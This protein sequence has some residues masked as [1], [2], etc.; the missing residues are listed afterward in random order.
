MPE[1]LFRRKKQQ[2][3][4]SNT[5]N[6]VVEAHQDIQTAKDKIK[7]KDQATA[8]SAA[9]TPKTPRDERRKETERNDSILREKD[10]FMELYKNKYP[11]DAARLGLTNGR[12]D[13]ETDGARGKE[14]GVAHVNG[15]GAANSNGVDHLNVSVSGL[16]IQYYMYDQNCVNR[17][18]HFYVSYL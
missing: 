6:D 10:K 13:L 12:A 9:A 4:R 15:V 11:E 17:N 8:N 16:R 2:S 5:L 7:K 3:R 1:F 18:A 14:R